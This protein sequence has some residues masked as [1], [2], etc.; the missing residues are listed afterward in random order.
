MGHYKSNLRDLEFN[1]F[2]VF[3]IQERLGTGPFAEMDVQSAQDVLRE[4]DRLATGPLAESFAE[5]DRN[6][7]VFDPDAHTVELPVA[8]RKSFQALWDGEWYRLDLPSDLGGFGAPATL[9]WATAEM[10][11]GSNPAAFIYMAGPSMAQVLHRNGTPEQQHWAELMIE[12]GWGATMVLTEPDAGS[13]VGAGRT[14]AVQQPDGSWHLEGVK[15][16]ITSAEH[17]LAENIVHL[18]LARPTGAGPG[19]KGLS[20]FFVPKYHFDPETGELGE[21]NGAFVTGVEHKMGLKVSTTCELTFG[22]HGTPAVGWLVGEVHDGIAQMF[23]VIEYARMMVGTKA[24][25]TLSSGYLTALD[26][27]KERVQGADITQLLNKSAPR[28]TITHHPDVRRMLMLQ[29]AYAEGLRALYL[30]TACFQDQVTLYRS[31]SA[32]DDADIAERVNDL[33]LPIVKG[34]GSERAYEM[35]TLSLQTLGGSG[36][37][38]DYPVE[39]YIRDAK[40]DSLYEGTTGIQAQDFFFRKIVRDKG[41]AM[42]YLNNEIQTFLDAEGGNGRLKEERALL[43][44]ALGDLQGMLA[45]MIGFLT[46]AQEDPRNTY[47]VAQQTVRFLMSAGDVVIGWLLLRQ[48]E[49]ALHAL[50]AEVSAKDRAFYDGKVAAASFFARNILPELTARRAIVEATDNAL[51]DVPEDAF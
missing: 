22:Q 23:Q 11:L 32:G 20:L 51:M 30:Y 12:K 41:Q 9:R 43:A 42:G 44:T 24:I 7:P 13:D 33:L 36:F 8:F 25:A 17:D 38:Q 27:A 26:Y 19:T 28:V 50:G 2:E 15:R 10:L 34:V 31:A 40:I 6:P 29:K 18:V 37:L 47:K 3:S 21:R 39:Q 35:L 1:L 48:A 16:F 49:T 45:A 4:I 14:K 5:A 46:S